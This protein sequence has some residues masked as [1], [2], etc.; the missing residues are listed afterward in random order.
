MGAEFESLTVAV[1]GGGGLRDPP[2]DG[3][4]AARPA[5][6]RRSRNRGGAPRRPGPGARRRHRRCPAAA[7]RP[8]TEHAG[9]AARRRDPRGRRDRRPRPSRLGYGLVDR[10]RLGRSP[11]HAHRRRAPGPSRRAHRP[12][13]A[14]RD[15][16]GG[17]DELVANMVA[18][19]TPEQRA[20]LDSLLASQAAGEDDPDRMDK[21]YMALWPSYSYI[22]GNVLPFSS[23]RI[24]RPVEGVPDTM[25]SVARTSRPAPWS[26]ACPASISAHRPRRGP[27][28]R[29]RREAP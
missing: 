25:T 10:A 9:G 14:R 27:T 6:P 19:L 23:L 29:A 16:D 21:L 22:H 18:R 13:D 24:E 17:S 8:V 15:P 5:P 1:P 26:A 20:H 2:R 28:A 11:R 12:R 3:R 4:G 7:A